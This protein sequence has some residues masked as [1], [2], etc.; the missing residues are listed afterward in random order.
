MSLVERLRQNAEFH[1]D[2]T[3]SEAADRIEALERA[4]ASVRVTMR[5]ARIFITSRQR[6]HHEGVLLYDQ[7]IADI[8]ALI[9]AA[10]AK[11]P[12]DPGQHR[13]TPEPT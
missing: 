8:D 2:P 1:R 10:S 11:P 3:C 6:M 13:P 12:A 4:L 5:H 7:D 9:P